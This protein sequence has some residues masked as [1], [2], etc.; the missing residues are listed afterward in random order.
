MLHLLPPPPPSIA[1]TRAITL[2]SLATRRN[3]SISESGDPRSPLCLLSIKLHQ[4]HSS[5]LITN[6]SARILLYFM[7]REKPTARPAAP[8]ASSSSSSSSSSSLSKEPPEVTLL[9]TRVVRRCPYSPFTTLHPNISRFT[10]QSLF[11]LSYAPTARYV[12]TSHL[13]TRETLQRPKRLRA[14]ALTSVGPLNDSLRCSS[15]APISKP[16]T[17]NNF[18]RI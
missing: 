1:I 7:P 6:P 9:R 10:R 13:K 18:T 17:S 3:Q 5:A 2:H 15:H 12:Q 16:Q 4:T 11:T 8:A 14:S